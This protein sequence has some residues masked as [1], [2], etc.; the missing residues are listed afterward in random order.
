MP[1]TDTE[2]AAFLGIAGHSKAPKIIAELTPEKR[3]LY[4]QM[5]NL[6]TEIALWQD[7]LGPK[8]TGV[9]ICGCKHHRRR[10]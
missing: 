9:I 1:M 7:G 6:E 3:A 10:R 5:A 4:D 8:P 2:L